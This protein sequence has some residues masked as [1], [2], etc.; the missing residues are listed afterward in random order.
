MG[1]RLDDR[2]AL[3]TGASSGIGRACAGRFAAAGARVL[4]NYNSD[5]DGAAEVVADIEREG[6]RAVAH[7]ADVGDEQAVAAMFSACQESLGPP[8]IL[9]ANAGVQRD[10]PLVDMEA[11]DWDVVLSTNLRGQFLC[12]RAAARSLQRRDRDGEARPTGAIVFMSSV[13]DH[14]PWAGRAHYAAAKGGA[15]MLMKSLA[16]E[17][18]PHRIRVNAISPGAIETEINR[19]EWEDE[20]ARRDLLRRIPADRVGSPEDVAKAALWLASD[21]SDYVHGHALTVDGG[22]S[23]YPSFQDA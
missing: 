12:A 7:Q 21:E 11:A 14:I 17:L 1:L 18:A 2:T 20:A 6:G 13:H 15:L 16:L 9:L 5:A 10:A 4:V 8:D 22:M 3:I 23:L 19:A